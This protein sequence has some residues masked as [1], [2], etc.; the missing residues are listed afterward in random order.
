M[1]WRLP[2]GMGRIDPAASGTV[3]FRGEGTLASAG[4]RLGSRWWGSRSKSLKPSDRRLRPGC[5]ATALPARVPPPKWRR[6]RQIL[7]QS[8]LAF[9]RRARHAN[10][11]VHEFPRNQHGERRQPLLV[12]AAATVAGTGYRFVTWFREA[13][14]GI[15]RIRTSAVTKSAT[16]QTATLSWSST[17]STEA[18]HLPDRTV[19]LPQELA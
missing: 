13:S 11:R 10:D 3:E 16:A 14:C 5:T 2:P 7:T 17:A 4:A 15:V 9:P 8:S 19:V 1:P 12:Q 6:H 18:F